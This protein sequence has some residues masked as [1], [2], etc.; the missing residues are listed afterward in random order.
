MGD[1]NSRTGKYPDSVSQER[2]NIITNDQS[3]YALSFNHRNSF[4]NEI[5]N[6]GKRLL[7]I[8]RSAD[9]RIL[10]GRVSDDSLGR[11][12]FHRRNETSV[13]DYAICDQDLFSTVAHFAVK[14]PSFF[15]DHSPVIVW[16]NIETNICNK[17]VARAN[18]S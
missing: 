8:C 4:D 2:N 12:T 18:D 6:N 14:E 10:N 1:L 11:A 15:S 5:N 3:K 9:L 16:L 13:V 7:E 17:N